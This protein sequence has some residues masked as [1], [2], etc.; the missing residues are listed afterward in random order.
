MEERVRRTE[1]RRKLGRKIYKKGR[2]YR[3]GEG[4]GTGIRGR[5]ARKKNGRGG[6]KKRGKIEPKTEEGGGKRTSEEDR[7]RWQEE[8]VGEK[9]DRQ[10]G[11]SWKG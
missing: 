4:K 8:K 7:E 10:E 1:E 9:A 3:R 11:K 6:R 5:E 2:K